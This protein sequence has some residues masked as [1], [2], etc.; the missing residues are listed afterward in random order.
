[1]EW[2]YNETLKGFEMTAEKDVEAGES[3][4]VSYRAMSN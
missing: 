1:V 3:L 4:Y 2:H